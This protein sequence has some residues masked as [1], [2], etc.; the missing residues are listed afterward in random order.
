MNAIQRAI[1]IKLKKYGLTI[2][3]KKEYMANLENNVWF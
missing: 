3:T 1:L 2:P